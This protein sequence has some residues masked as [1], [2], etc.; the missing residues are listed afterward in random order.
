[1][2]SIRIER[3]QDGDGDLHYEATLFV[4]V[5]VGNFADQDVT[6]AHVID[7]IRSVIH[8]QADGEVEIIDYSTIR[9]G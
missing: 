6:E 1:V 3:W 5:V 8:Q 9:E 2:V 7:L 4:A